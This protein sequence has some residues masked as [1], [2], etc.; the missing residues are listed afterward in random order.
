[1]TASRYPADRCVAVGLNQNRRTLRLVGKRGNRHILNRVGDRKIVRLLQ[2]VPDARQL[3]QRMRLE[4]QTE[5][6]Q[7]AVDELLREEIAAENR[8]VVHGLHGDS[9]QSLLGQRVGRKRRNQ[10]GEVK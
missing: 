2:R 6:L 7:A 1:M 5:G 3:F 8:M 4:M 10:I 9:E